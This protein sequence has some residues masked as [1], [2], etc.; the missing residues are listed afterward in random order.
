MSKDSQD[1]DF[2]LLIV[3]GG[4]V[5]AAL[6]LAVGRNTPYRVA[7]LESHRVNASSGQGH[8]D[9]RSVAIAHGSRLIFTQ[10]GLDAPL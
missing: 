6:A 3:G 5:G 1:H 4:L 8:F 9:D 10:L 7:L 2:D